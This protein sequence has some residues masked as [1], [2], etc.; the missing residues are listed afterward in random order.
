MERNWRCADDA[1]RRVI[2]MT[3]YGGRWSVTGVTAVRRR[4]TAVR[5]KR[6]VTGMTRDLQGHRSLMGLTKSI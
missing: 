5:G 6:G 1:Q 4:R 2:G 3:Q